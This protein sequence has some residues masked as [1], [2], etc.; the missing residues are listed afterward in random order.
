VA[1]GRSSYIQWGL[2]FLVA[3]TLLG[4][5][6]VYGQHQMH[7]DENSAAHPAVSQGFLAEI[8]AS[9]IN[10]APSS[11]VVDSA[12]AEVNALRTEISSLLDMVKRHD[13]MLRYVMGRYVE[14]DTVP[15]MPGA[16]PSFHAISHEAVVV[17]FSKPEFVSK[18]G[19]DAPSGSEDSVVVAGEI[20][21]KRK[22]GGG[23]ASA[24]T[25]YDGAQEMPAVSPAM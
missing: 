14:K 23:D 17:N 8:A 9:A 15:S 21:K 5:A 12:S 18:S 6:F 13:K 22:G 19:N 25:L 20:F 1:R 2:F 7:D 24:F 10:A 3:L 16:M 11:A 4:W